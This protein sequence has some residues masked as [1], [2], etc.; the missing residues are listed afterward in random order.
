M[1]TGIDMAGTVAGS[2]SSSEE[3]G[4]PPLLVVGTGL[5]DLSHVTS[6]VVAIQPKTQESTRL[7]R[8]RQHFIRFMMSC[9]VVFVIL[10]VVSL[11]AQYKGLS[12]GI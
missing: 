5:V 6:L 1:E 11:F 12:R 7:W 4:L 10:F 8:G 3:L 9:W 2:V